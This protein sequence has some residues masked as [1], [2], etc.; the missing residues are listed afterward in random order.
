[1]DVSLEP[2]ASKCSAK[3]KPWWTLKHQSLIL[4]KTGTSTQRVGF[5][6]VTGCF[7]EEKNLLLLPG[8]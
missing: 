5:K 1:M 8:I 2:I 7:A 6:V 3:V 4:G